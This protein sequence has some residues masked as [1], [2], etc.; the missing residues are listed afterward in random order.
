MTKKLAAKKVTRSKLASV[1]DGTIE[2]MDVL[3]PAF[4]KDLLDHLGVNRPLNSKLVDEYA[5]A[6]SE[7]RWRWVGDTIRLNSDLQ[8][9]D[10]QH[11]LAACVRSGV[12]MRNVIL[13]TLKSP[14]A[15]KSIDRGKVRSL[16]D[17]LIIEG[18]GPIDSCILAGVMA[19]KVGWIDIKGRY[20]REERIDEYF[21]CPF[22][23]RLLKLRS[24]TKFRKDMWNAGPISAA[25]RCMRR[26]PDAAMMFFGS[27][28]TGS[29]QCYDDV[30]VEPSKM[31]FQFLINRAR[32]RQNMA[33]IREAAY[34]GIRAYNM[35]RTGEHRDMLRY[36]DNVSIPEV[37]T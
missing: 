2:L 22:L 10:G 17:Q 19:E 31:Y 29:F 35:W 11:R 5:R 9:I 13:V 14:D 32:N 23:D 4:A 12:A 1:E 18:L 15:I 33:P 37:E 3:E 25:L 30:N 26:N 6:M 34:K 28:L 27:V 16:R 20:S 7:H 8:V 24:I 36:A 21:A